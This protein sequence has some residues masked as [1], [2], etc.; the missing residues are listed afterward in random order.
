MEG[1]VYR[2]KEKK[3]R[4]ENELKKKSVSCQYNHDH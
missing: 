2:K 4:F 3:K 1:Q